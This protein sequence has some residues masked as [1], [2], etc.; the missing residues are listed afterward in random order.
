MAVSTEGWQTPLPRKV[1]RVCPRRKKVEKILSNPD[2]AMCMMQKRDSRIGKH[3]IRSTECPSSGGGTEIVPE[4]KSSPSQ[5][6]IKAD[7]ES[8]SKKSA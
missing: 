4:W 2:K 6:V 5:R 3:D 1:S 8:M 7:R